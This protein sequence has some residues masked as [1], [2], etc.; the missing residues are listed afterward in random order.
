MKKKCIFKLLV[1]FF[2]NFLVVYIFLTYKFVIQ[3]SEIG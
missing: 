3:T 2:L 1:E